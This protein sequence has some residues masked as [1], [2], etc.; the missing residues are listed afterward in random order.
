MGRLSMEN[1]IHMDRHE[2]RPC[3]AIDRGVWTIR[4]VAWLQASLGRPRVNRATS[5]RNDPCICLDGCIHGAEFALGCSRFHC[6]RCPGA[7]ACL[8]STSMMCPH[9][10]K[11]ALRRQLP[12]RRCRRLR[13]TV[14]ISFRPTRRG[15]AIH[16]ANSAT[17]SV[18]AWMIRASVA[19]FWGANHVR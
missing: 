7:Q 11:R 6:W 15:S 8:G 9:R 4:G 1:D 5:A 18:R 10:L 16:L 19:A 12:P 17:I 3:E 13:E 2:G 14:S